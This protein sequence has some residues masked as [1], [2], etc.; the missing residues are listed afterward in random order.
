VL[1]TLFTLE[2]RNSSLEGE[3]EALKRMIMAAEKQEYK[4][5]QYDE[6]NR[7]MTTASNN[8]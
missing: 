4:R 2:R 7:G 1:N 6:G 8:T 5:G 3:N